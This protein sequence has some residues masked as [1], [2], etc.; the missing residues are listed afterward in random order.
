MKVDP[1]QRYLHV[2]SDEEALADAVAQA[3]LATADAMVR[4][5]GAF[6]IA[7]AGGNTPRRTHAALLRRGLAARADL[8]VW[9]LWFGDERCVP[10][11]DAASN[12]RM[13]DESLLEGLRVRPTVHRV[14]TE[15]GAASV[16]AAAYE[17]EL[18]RAFALRPGAIPVFDMVLLGLGADGHTASI[19]PGDAALGERRRLV[20]P[21]KSPKP[22]HDRVT[23]TLPVLCA[24]SMVLFVVSGADKAPVLRLALDEDMGLP[25][26]EVRPTSGIVN[27]FADAAAASLVRKHK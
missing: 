13:V 4:E 15:L 19:F 10:P 1:L 21:A 7:L 17:A 20:A 23:L 18:V 22:P 9:D 16:I 25:V 12:A 24:A 14:P 5:H 6:R 11:G 26:D 8:A 2:L 3:I 27:F